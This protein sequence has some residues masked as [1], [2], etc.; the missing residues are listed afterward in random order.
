M[1]KDLI[2]SVLL[3]GIAGAY[4]YA[5]TDIPASA[6]DDE[7]G[8]HGLPTVLAMVLAIVAVAIAARSIVSARTVS[9][10]AAAP[11]PAK[12]SEAP[13]PRALGLLGIGILYV[14]VVDVLGYFV[15]IFLLLAGIAMYEG[16]KPSWRVV[17]VSLGGAAFFWLLFAY[18]L[19]IRQP[20]GL[21]F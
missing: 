11:E 5:S 13:W 17:A 19:G 8:P 18:G 1:R 9:N 16:L 3:L 14:P 20:A 6:L 12:E 21:L 4:Y 2:S 10:I 15:T 7:I